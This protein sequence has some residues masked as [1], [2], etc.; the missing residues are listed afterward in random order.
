MNNSLVFQT[1]CCVLF[2]AVIY[3]AY[4]SFFSN[5]QEGL[6]TNDIIK[7]AKKTITKETI[8]KTNKIIQQSER[9]LLSK[10]DDLVKK[11]TQ[12]L[13]KQIKG[14]SSAIKKEIK[15]IISS[16][17]KAIVDPILFAV[18]SMGKI[19]ILLSALFM[20]MMRKIASLPNCILSYTTWVMNMLRINIFDK[21]IPLILNKLLNSIFPD[22]IASNINKFIIFMVDLV[23]YLFMSF[24][25]FFGLT[26]L[27][28]SSEC[29]DFV[30][31]ANKIFAKIS[32]VAKET[33][34]NFK[35]NFGKF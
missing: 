23:V 34:T 30:D 2:I 18:M 17:K 28:Y 33:N 32:N 3:I 15:S 27:F 29:F 10:M 20:L 25:S 7:R 16:I 31:E 9:K 5:N 12:P 19:F 14:V 24:A 6:S 22:F 1:I 8:G 35:R 4:L 26:N 21:I 13:E 11:S